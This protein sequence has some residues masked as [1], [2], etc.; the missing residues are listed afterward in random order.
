MEAIT[1]FEGD[2][3]VA[4]QNAL[5][6]EWL[7]PIMKVITMFGESG[8]F[9]IAC[10]VLMLL[11]RKTRRLGII[12]SLSLAFTFICCNLVVKPIVDR[13]RPWVTFEA[14]NAMLP[15][16]GDASFPSGHSANAMGPA[17]ALF[18]STMPVRHRISNADTGSTRTIRTYDDVAPLGWKGVNAD[19][20]F[21]HRLGAAGVVLAVLIG[22][23]RMYLGMH[24]P[25]D[26]ICGLL[27]G[28]ICA[29]I[30]HAFIKKVEA[31]RGIIGG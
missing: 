13:E 14:V 10:C 8:F 19:P 27:L 24:Y 16:P 15:P 1:Q 30:V 21:A 2:L 26:V 3:L 25:S 7:T 9:W 11:F 18:I 20:R 12:C 22:I 29:T 6:A 4:I 31:K 23:S 28:M 17:W 5:N